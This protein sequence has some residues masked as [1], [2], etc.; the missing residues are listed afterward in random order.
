MRKLGFF[1]F[2]VYTLGEL[3]FFSLSV[4]AQDLKSFDRVK[5]LED[6]ISVLEDYLKLRFST[7]EKALQEKEDSIGEW[8]KQS[9]NLTVQMQEAHEKIS[10]L[11][12]EIEA[13]KQ[14]RAKKITS[15]KAKIEP[16][17]NLQNI[18]TNQPSLSPEVEKWLSLGKTGDS[19]EQK[20]HAV[21]QLN[22]QD[23]LDSTQA[24]SFLLK[25]EDYYVRMAVL[26]SLAKK[27]AKKALPMVLEMLN[28]K[29][30]SVR[31]Q[32]HVTLKKITGL[33]VLYN[34][35]SNKDKRAQGFANWK[36]EIQKKYKE[37]R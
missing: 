8:Q 5:I 34:P 17:T 16:E 27:Q 32:A 13:L 11:E 9:R 6:K 36:N 1:L 21:K 18:E 20:L 31:Q 30:I 23:R 2:F 14:D 28:D 10:L 29:D 22:E 26:K 33:S 24:L 3:N 37:E 25:E 15:E 35:Q 4:Y 7:F 12:K 19:L